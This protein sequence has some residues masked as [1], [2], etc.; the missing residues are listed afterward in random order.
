MNNFNISGINVFRRLAG[1]D[2]PAMDDLGRA[3]IKLSLN[4]GDPLFHAAE[5]KPFVYVVNRG[6][7]KLVYET[8]QGDSW[9]KGF[10]DAGICFASLM[11]LQEKGATSFS[12]YAVTDVAIEQID[13]RILQQLAD[14]HIEWQRAI[15]N[16]F[17]FYGQRK[18]QREMEL[19]TLSPEQRYLN[20]IQQYAHLLPLIKQSDIASYIRITPVA[21]SRIRAR[22]K[23]SGKISL[24]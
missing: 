8:P 6:V 13:Y 24:L 11:A 22:I 4:A 5:Q 14:Q 3:T 10:V 18:E 20:F 15:S 17:K 12:V 23:A 1:M 21:L 2:L 16:A 19:L 9:I 7:L